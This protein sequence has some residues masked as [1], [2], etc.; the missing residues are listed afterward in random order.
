MRQ[1]LSA[2][3]CAGP[4]LLA[5]CATNTPKRPAEPPLWTASGPCA[6]S[7]AELPVTELAPSKR[8]LWRGDFRSAAA[9]LEQASTAEPVILLALDAA[10]AQRELDLFL[11]IG[12]EYLLGASVKVLDAS[13][14]P[15]RHHGF[16]EFVARGSY[17]SLRLFPRPG[18]SA[19]YPLSE[20]D[21][22]AHAS[23]TDRIT[24]QR[25]QSMWIAGGYMGAIADG[26]EP[27]QQIAVRETGHLSLHRV[28]EEPAPASRQQSRR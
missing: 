3:I 21:R 9:C 12:K 10:S 19:S 15:L 23:G 4:L 28:E 5:G 24:G 20:I 25:V 22:T 16:D 6:A 13:R 2:L 27:Q 11:H 8:A 17:F 1:A 18:S 26:I 7:L 14:T